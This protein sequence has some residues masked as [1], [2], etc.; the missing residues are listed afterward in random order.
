MS[1]SPYTAAAAP[2]PYGQHDSVLR[3]QHPVPGYERWIPA[4]LPPDRYPALRSYGTIPWSH[5]GGAN[6]VAGRRVGQVIC[7]HI[8]CL[9][10]GDRTILG[11][12][13]SLLEFADF[14]CQSRLITNGR[15]HTSQQRRN[16][17]TCLDITENVVD[18]QQ[19]VLVLFI[20]EVLLPW[21]VRSRLHA[22]VLRGARSSEPKTSAVFS[23]TPDSFISLHR[24]LPSRNALRHQ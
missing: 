9:D 8:N 2:V 13:D 6:V 10:R 14:V 24:S 22:Y 4:D 15:R 19:H 11:R 20:T 7:R 18:K 21:S 23:R 3:R 1:C 12:S 17:G 5:P 16:L